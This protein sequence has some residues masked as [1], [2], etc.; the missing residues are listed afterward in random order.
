MG[1]IHQTVQPCAASIYHQAGCEAPP[2]TSDVWGSSLYEAGP[3]LANS[4]SRQA[5]K[6]A[7]L[8]IRVARFEHKD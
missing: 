3:W 6:T 8:L 4:G 7:W 2:V 5:T 1:N